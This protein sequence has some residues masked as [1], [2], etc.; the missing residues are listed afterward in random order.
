MSDVLNLDL[1]NSKSFIGLDKYEITGQLRYA[2][3]ESRMRLSEKQMASHQHI[4]N[5]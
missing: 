5:L 3:P 2:T 1:P 4:G